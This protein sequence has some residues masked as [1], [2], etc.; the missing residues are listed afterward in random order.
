M[1][2][3]RVLVIGYGSIGK[4]HLS[5]VRKNSSNVQIMIFHHARSSQIPEMADS[6]TSSITDV[7]DFNPDVAIVANP[8]PFHLEMANAL[9]DLGCHLF[10][11]KPISNKVEG[12]AEFLKKVDESNLICQVGYNLRFMLSLSCF[13][14]LI[15][16]GY[17]GRPLSVRCE[18]GQY[19][20]SWRPDIDYRNSVSSR[21]ELGGGA[22]LELSHEI[23]YL[24]WIFGEVGWVNAWI[25]KVSELEIDVEDVA[26]LTI[27]FMAEHLEKSVVA[28]VNLDLFR[29]DPV[30]K[31]VLVGEKGSLSWNGISGCVDHFDP[32]EAKWKEV[33]LIP[34]LRNE[35]YEVQWAHFLTCLKNNQKPLVDGLE[36]LRTLEVIDMARRSA[37]ANGIKIK[38]LFAKTK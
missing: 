30:R 14:D 16:R 35:S 5:I 24:R 15:N 18:V 10:I 34:P 37:R 38:S 33:M 36:G 20:P 13:R 7:L 21:S 25:G 31:C 3:E 28:N 2:I 17:V 32:L 12:V 22:L 26:H 19:L 8:A 29:Q 27:G 11:E 6:V 9:A 4:R 1:P 23:D